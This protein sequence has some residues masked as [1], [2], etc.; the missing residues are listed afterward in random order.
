MNIQIYRT[1]VSIDPPAFSIGYGDSI[2][3]IGSC[4]S[5]H[6]GKYMADHK[7]TIDINPYGQQ[8]NP[9]S[10]AQGLARLLEP[11]PHTASDLVLHQG[12]YHSM[13]HHSSFSSD[14]VEGTLH[15]IN[16]RLS[17]AS[18]ALK[19]AS[20]LML[21]YGTAHVFRHRASGQIVSNCHKLPSSTFDMEMVMADEIVAATS[22]VLQDIRAINPHIRVILTVS[23]VR[24]FAFGHAINTVSKAQLFTAIYQ[25][26]RTMNNVY[27]FP[28]Y[29]LVIDDLRDYRYYADDMLHPSPLAIQYVWERFAETLLHTDTHLIMAEIASIL[30]AIQH[31]PRHA[32]GEAHQRFIHTQI[33]KIDA[34]TAKTGLDLSHEHKVLCNQITKLKR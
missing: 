34:L 5:E 8:Y 19:Q 17:Q 15:P 30:S 22:Q 4:F 14:T 24:Y 33:A 7:F 20:V 28:A 25:L 27:Y 23:P 32:V 16:E 29:E 31:R 21:T 12:L 13:A 10:I 1:V 11:V 2:V 3:N 6:I 26:Q 9:L 18:S